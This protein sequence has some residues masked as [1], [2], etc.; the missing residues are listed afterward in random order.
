MEITANKITAIKISD[1]AV[2]EILE[3]YPEEG[4]VERQAFQNAFTSGSMDFDLLKKESQTISVPWQLFLLKHSKLK[5]QLE[6]IEKQRIHKVSSKLMAKRKGSGSVTSKRIIDRLIRQQNYLLSQSRF[7]DNSLCGLL[8]HHS[9]Q[10]AAA[11]LT[12]F[13]EF[14]QDR[15]WKVSSKESAL[16]HLIKNVEAKNINVSRGVLSNKILPHIASARDVYRNTSGFVIKDTK[17]PFIFLPS[18][19]NPDEVASR[20]IYTLVYLLVIIGLEEYN[21]FLEEDFNT[22]LLTASKMEKRTHAITSEVLIPRVESDKLKSVEVTEAI[23]NEWCKKLKVSPTAF[24]TALR[25][26][27]VIDKSKYEELLP[28]PFDPKQKKKSQ[29]RTPRV[30]SSAR[31]FCGMYSYD[32]IN[33]GIKS[34]TLASTQAQY[35]LFGTINKAGYK[36]YRNELGI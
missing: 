5:Q 32:A 30:S 29:A 36:K 35:L 14:D 24:V 18:E 9:V 16:D 20:Q 12:K 3:L 21:Y 6:H 4:L 10:K 7:L 1:T 25:I 28:E 34:K 33:N 22:K 2:R 15:F 8:K 31:K 11:K 17:V 26:R 27:R 23:R 19:I 13:I